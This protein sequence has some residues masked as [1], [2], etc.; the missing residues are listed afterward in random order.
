MGEGGVP[1]FPLNDVYE[2]TEVQVNNFAEPPTPAESLELV[3]VINTE[4]GFR[5]AEL[6]WGKGFTI[7]FKD[8][9]NGTIA[10]RR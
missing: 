9:M 7:T 1:E 2:K 8:V 10:R 3:K 5:N 4:E 6:R